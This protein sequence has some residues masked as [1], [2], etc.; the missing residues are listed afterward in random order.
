MPWDVECGQLEGR[1]VAIASLRA[2]GGGG[3]IRRFVA[4]FIAC[5]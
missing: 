5:G 4:R 1:H 3:W 2:L